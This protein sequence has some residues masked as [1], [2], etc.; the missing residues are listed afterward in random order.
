MSHANDLMSMIA[1]RTNDFRREISTLQATLTDPRAIPE[2]MICTSRYVSPIGYDKVNTFIPVT[3]GILGSP[4]FAVADSMLPAAVETATQRGGFDYSDGRVEDGVGWSLHELCSVLTYAGAMPES[5]AVERTAVDR[6]LDTRFLAPFMLFRLQAWVG[7]AIRFNDDWKQKMAAS[8]IRRSDEIAHR[9]RALMSIRVMFKP[10]DEPGVFTL[11]M[12]YGLELAPYGEPVDYSNSDI[13]GMQGDLEQVYA[14]WRKHRL[15]TLPEKPCAR[16]VVDLAFDQMVY[17]LRVSGSRPMALIPGL[18]G[19]FTFIDM[20]RNYL[21]HT[22]LSN[23][24]AMPLTDGS[25]RI[26]GAVRID[27][28]YLAPM[29]VGR[30]SRYHRL[31]TAKDAPGWS[32]NFFGATPHQ[33][34][35]AAASTVELMDSTLKMPKPPEVAQQLMFLTSELFTD[36]F[37][38]DLDT[39]TKHA[40]RF[41]R[42]IVEYTHRCASASAKPVEYQMMLLAGVTMMFMGA[43]LPDVIAH[44]SVVLPMDDEAAYDVIRAMTRS[45]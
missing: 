41:N 35:T 5:T 40:E 21:A 17:A 39:A 27:S 25:Q 34:R 6:A 28:S 11:D 42:Y 1:L 16:S 23:V 10:G 8:R 2:R 29:F 4:P 18:E 22:T 30:G 26:Y 3:N 32:F 12:P 9:A 43:V 37:D 33:P 15:P 44:R 24:T 45:R 7:Q 13:S 20:V 14:Q 36:M 19:A 38:G 31:F